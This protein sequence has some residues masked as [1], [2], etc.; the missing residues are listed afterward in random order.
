MLVG[1][2]GLDFLNIPRE[3]AQFGG[4]SGHW[5]PVVSFGYAA[6][7]AAFIL[8][9]QKRFPGQTLL[10]AA[11]ISLGRPLA[12]VGNLAFLSVFFAWLVFA[13]RDA[14]DLVLIYLLSRTPLWAASTFFVLGV[15]YLSMG[16]LTAVSRLACFVVIPGAAIRL[17][18]QLVAFQGVSVTHLL[19]LIAVRP[20]RLVIGGLSILNGFLPLFAILLIHPLLT[21]KERLGR[22]LFIPISIAAIIFYTAVAGTIGKFGT[23]LTML[24]SWPN[25][26]SVA[27]VSIPYLVIEQLGLVFLILWIILFF[28]AAGWYVQVV[29]HGVR[30]AFPRIPYRWAAAAT[31]SAIWAAG[32]LFPNTLTVHS[33][34]QVLRQW[35][36][37]PAFFYPFV[38]YIVSWIRGVKGD[39][40]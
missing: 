10:Q 11:R 2:L 25:L 7:A 34:F 5:I 13:V 38:V 4:A 17:A 40:Y 12:F 20:V 30:T 39:Q 14:M 33:A 3:A 23:E 18:M 19:P 32:L 35:A 26:A 16:G 21:R 31:L 28:V 8:Q 6:L 15:A 22:V 36:T 29:A 1:L 27:T 24:F 37:L 9:F